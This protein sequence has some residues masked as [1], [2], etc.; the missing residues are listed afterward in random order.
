[1]ALVFLFEKNNRAFCLVFG[2]K[3]NKLLR[4]M[5]IRDSANCSFY[6]FRIIPLVNGNNVFGIVGKIECSVFR[7]NATT[8]AKV[9][10][11]SKIVFRFFIFVAAASR[12]AGVRGPVAVCPCRR[13][14][15]AGERG[16]GWRCRHL[17]ERRQ[18]AGGRAFFCPDVSSPAASA[19]WL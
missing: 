18:G 19:V 13:G 6:I 2:D 5:Y 16:L 4:T 11:Y 1:M 9:S 14:P 17:A 7:N 12:W 10:P 8:I 15:C 3:Y